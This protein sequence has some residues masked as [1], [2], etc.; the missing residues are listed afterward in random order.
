M[1]HNARPRNLDEAYAAASGRLFAVT[2]VVHHCP[3]CS[4]STMRDTKLIGHLL[5][6]H[7][8]TTVHA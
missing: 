6:A 4:F 2:P 3:C 7:P 5:R 1:K 8:K